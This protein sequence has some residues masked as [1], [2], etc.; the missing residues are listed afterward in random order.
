MITKK[1]LSDGAP[2]V[3]AIRVTDSDDVQVIE[4]APLTIQKDFSNNDAAGDT[5]EETATAGSTGNT[6][7]IVVTNTGNVTLFDVEI[8]DPDLGALSCLPAQPTTLAPAG[9]LVC[10]G[11]YAVGQGDIDSGSYTNTASAR[12]ETG[13]GEEV[14]DGDSA[15]AVGPAPRRARR[16]RFADPSSLR[17]GTCTRPSRCGGG[18]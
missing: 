8:T 6:Y 17:S 3:A 9:S 13:D 5:P 12:G 15:T 7:R 16:A 2:S 4:N 1:I 10:T 18:A 14:E 11:G